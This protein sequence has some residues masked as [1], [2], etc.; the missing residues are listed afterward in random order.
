M[1]PFT[2]LETAVTILAFT[3]EAHGGSESDLKVGGRELRELKLE[4]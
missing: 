4:L 2:A 3:D 1:I